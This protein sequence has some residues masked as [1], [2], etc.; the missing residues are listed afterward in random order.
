LLVAAT[1]RTSTFDLA[2]RGPLGDGAPLSAGSVARLKAGWQAEYELWWTRSLTE[3]EPV[4]LWVDGI[5]VKAG[6]EKAKAA[7]AWSSLD[8]ETVAR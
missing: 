5:D 6:L 8:C 7:C 2:L 1:T 4:F 3:L